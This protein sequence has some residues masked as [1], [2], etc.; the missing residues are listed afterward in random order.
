MKDCVD[1]LTPK[2]LTEFRKKPS[3]KDGHEP[4]CK[5]CRNIRYNK[6]D[7]VRVFKK[8]Y[9]SQILHSQR[10]GH[11]PPQYTLE[12][13]LLWV[14]A[15]PN[16]VQLWD[17]YRDSNYNSTLKPSVDRLN[18][19]FGYS[20]DNIQ[21]ISWNENR[22]KGAKAKMAGEMSSARPVAAYNLDG[23]HHK[24]FTTTSEAARYVNASTSGIISVANGVPIKDGRGN[25]YLPKTCKSY[26]WAWL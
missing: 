7:P 8:I 1:C 3:C 13:F 20:L 10:R 5:D 16:S 17:T 11:T 18:D 25:L 4:R 22:N 2:P 19:S 26:I 12:E 6:A 23:T 21:L 9:N 14:D 15:Q 24:N